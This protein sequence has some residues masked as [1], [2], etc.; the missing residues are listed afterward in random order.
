MRKKRRYKMVSLI[1]SEFYKM[2]HTLFYPLHMVIPILF[3]VLFLAYYSYTN[4]SSVSK[5]DGY[6][7]A[8]AIGFP[9]IVSIIC[10]MVVEKDKE[11]GEYKELIGNVYSKAQCFYS[12]LVM[13]LIM[14]ILSV[15]IAVMLFYIGFDCFLGQNELSLGCYIMLILIIYGGQLFSYAFHMILTFIVGKGISISVGILE[16]L[17]AA[18]LYMGLGEGIWIYFPG[19]YSNRFFK[20]YMDWYLSSGTASTISNM[21][22]IIPVVI[23]I[24]GLIGAGICFNRFE[25]RGITME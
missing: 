11:A 1:K 20:H 25:G 22:I 18:I 24:A 8:M 21:E 13:T 17:F 15:L 12:K 5:V 10:S 4:Y 16:S 6:F 7:Q 2:K 19:C 14:G 23:I 3:S 9:F